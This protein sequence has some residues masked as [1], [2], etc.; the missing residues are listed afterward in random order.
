M[1]A[2]VEAELLSVGGRELEVNRT[3][4]K[5]GCRL[6]GKCSSSYYHDSS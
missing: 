2:F 4:F 5:T 6:S 1:K 3:G